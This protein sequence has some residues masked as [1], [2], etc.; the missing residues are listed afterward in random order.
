MTL[1]GLRP[2]VLGGVGSGP[3]GCGRVQGV[4]TRHGC[5]LVAHVK[6][7]LRARGILSLQNGWFKMKFGPAICARHVL[8]SVLTYSP[9]ASSEVQLFCV[10]RTTRRE[11]PQAADLTV[12]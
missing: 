7:G 3:G 12:A 4:S 6:G 9:A 10:E 2:C 1:P 11:S 5:H 8:P